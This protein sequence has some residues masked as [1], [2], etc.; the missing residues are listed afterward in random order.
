MP[1]MDG[2]TVY[3]HLLANPHTANI[4]VIF[5]SAIDE[6][7]YKEHAL[8]LGSADYINPSCYLKNKRMK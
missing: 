5:L 2:F 8:N 7:D 1:E 6:I 3:Q 4:L